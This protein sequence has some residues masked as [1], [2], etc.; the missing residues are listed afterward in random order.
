MQFASTEGFSFTFHVYVWKTFR[1][2]EFCLKDNGEG[3]RKIVATIEEKSKSKLSAY[4]MLN[5]T[6][7]EDLDRFLFVPVPVIG[8]DAN[9]ELLIS[10][11]CWFCCVCCCCCDCCCCCCGLL[12]ATCTE[13]GL[14]ALSA[15]FLPFFSFPFFLFPPRFIRL[16][17][18]VAN[19]SPLS[20]KECSFSLQTSINDSR[21]I[22]LALGGEKNAI[23]NVIGCHTVPVFAPWLDASRRDSTRPGE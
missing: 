7:P 2:E 10:G 18:R 1:R 3:K 11:G 22:F 23:R 14:A 5:I 13:P 19:F 20:R 17:I 16:S 12:A 15:I 21:D 6:L 9:C 8:G 4:M